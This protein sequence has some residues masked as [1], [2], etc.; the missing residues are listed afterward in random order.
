MNNV[1]VDDHKTIQMFSV[2]SLCVVDIK[3]K[4]EV[5]IP[6]PVSLSD[7]SPHCR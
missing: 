7:R 6:V 1:C 2:M 4:K 5:Q 3:D